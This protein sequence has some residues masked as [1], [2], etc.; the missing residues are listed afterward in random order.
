MKIIPNAVTNSETKE[1]NEKTSR[2]TGS[3]LKTE[4]NDFSSKS[5]QQSELL[6][7]LMQLIE[8]PSSNKTRLTEQNSIPENL[9]SMSS[10]ENPRNINHSGRD[11]ALQMTWRGGALERSNL[12]SRSRDSEIAPSIYV[13]PSSIENLTFENELYDIAHSRVEKSEKKREGEFLSTPDKKDVS[14][15]KMSELSDRLVTSEVSFKQIELD[16]RGSKSLESQSILDRKSSGD[17]DDRQT[18]V[19]PKSNRTP[20]ENNQRELPLL[21]PFSFMS[22]KSRADDSRTVVGENPIS[23]QG[24]SDKGEQLKDIRSQENERIK[25]S[26]KPNI[27]AS[28]FSRVIEER[29]LGQRVITRNGVEKHDSRPLSLNNSRLDSPYAEDSKAHT[30]PKIL[31]VFDNA[32]ES[33]VRIVLSVYENLVQKVSDLLAEQNSKLTKSN[34]PQSSEKT[35]GQVNASWTVNTE[36]AS[37]EPSKV[38]VD[39][40]TFDGQRIHVQLENNQLL[41][42][43]QARTTVAAFQDNELAQ[44]EHLL[45]K[46]FPSL[47]VSCQLIQDGEVVSKHAEAN[48]KQR[49]KDDEDQQGKKRYPFEYYLDEELL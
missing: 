6:V 13:H 25:I 22:D 14:Y 48:E 27:Q 30:Q 35:T 31:D 12:E 5:E 11:E 42:D 4:R 23:H 16:I 44:L 24:I 34:N 21:K 37:K 1:I 15:R 9:S 26:E 43:F 8:E 3:G 17:F 36:G 29:E 49:E 20:I 2:A 10:N 28:V 40:K 19:S 32:H 18:H 33:E 47:K 41:V 39:I 45:E 38:A 7:Q 46:R